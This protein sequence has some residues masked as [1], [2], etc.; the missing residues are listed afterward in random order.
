[1]ASIKGVIVLS[2]KPEGGTP[3]NPLMDAFTVPTPVTP[4]SRIDM[5]KIRGRADGA[6][7]RNEHF[8]I[9]A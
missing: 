3:A 1:M 7:G 9:G 6:G 5:T 2:S 4:G 8:D